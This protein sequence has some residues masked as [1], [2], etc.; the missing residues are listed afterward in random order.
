MPQYFQFWW[1]S[2][3]LTSTAGR[4]VCT[5]GGLY[6]RARKYIRQNALL[7]QVRRRKISYQ[8]ARVEV[9]SDINDNQVRVR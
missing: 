7:A 8:F 4:T 6:S 1:I 2:L 3:V 5:R 9:F